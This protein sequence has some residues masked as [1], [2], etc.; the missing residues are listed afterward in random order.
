MTPSSQADHDIVA[1]YAR[2]HRLSFTSL[3]R[4][5]SC[6]TGISSLKHGT[7]TSRF[8]FLHGSRLNALTWTGVCLHLAR[9]ALCL[10]LPGHGH[11]QPCAAEDYTIAKMADR[12]A[13]KLAVE[14]EQPVILVGHSL[15]GI[16]AIEVAARLGARVAGLVLIDS[17]P[18]GAGLPAPEV[19]PLQ[20][21]SL[22]DM[23]ADLGRLYPRKSR[24]SLMHIIS[25]E[26]V[27]EADGQWRWQWDRHYFDRAELRRAERTAVWAQFQALKLPKISIA[28]EASEAFTAADRRQL[29]SMLPEIDAYLLPGA[30]H[31]VHLDRP[32]GVATILAG[33]EARVWTHGG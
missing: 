21:G 2:H 5:T 3:R 33:L 10:D 22:E 29:A 8:V 17:S 31:N 1:S 15:G 18:Q 11:S 12:L 27:E 14:I 9:P 19:L 23:L 7:A 25:R 24:Q 32:M 26:C 6:P 28:G 4:S 16:C 13:A 30:G 20:A